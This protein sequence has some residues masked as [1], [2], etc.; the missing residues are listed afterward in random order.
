[1][2]GPTFDIA[3]IAQVSIIGRLSLQYL[4]VILLY[5]HGSWVQT[6]LSILNHPYYETINQPS[7]NQCSNS[8]SAPELVIEKLQRWAA[9]PCSERFF[10][11]TLPGSH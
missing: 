4:Q 1:M 10:W 11:V 8:N 6:S 2:L 9:G 5:A 3:L 7:T